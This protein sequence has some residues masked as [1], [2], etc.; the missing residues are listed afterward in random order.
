MLL[1]PLAAQRDRFQDLAEGYRIF[2]AKSVKPVPTEPN[3]QQAL[4]KWSGAIEFKDKLYRGTADCTVLL[5]RIRKSK[6]P[7]TGV[8]AGGAPAEGGGEPRDQDDEADAT[9]RDEVIAARNG[10]TT[11]DEFLKRR[12]LPSDLEAVD[13]EKPL[14]SKDGVPFVARKVIGKVFDFRKREEN[15]VAVIRTYML[16]D[17]AEYFGLVAQG[18]WLDPWKDLVE[19][20]AKSLQ[21]TELGADDVESSDSKFGNQEFRDAVRKK[22]VKG[23]RAFD[24]EHFVFV[25]NTKDSGLIQQIMVDLELMRLNYIERF[26]PVA[27]VDLDQVISAVRFC[28]TYDDYQAYGGPPGT[29]GYWNFVDEELVL[30]DMQTLDEKAYRRNPELK[31]IQV[32]D[33]LYH[34]AMH[35]YFFYANG[36]LAPASWFNEGFGEVFAGAVPDRRKNEIRKIDKN[37]FRLAVI[38]LAQ[39]D[40]SW[41]DL[42]KLLRMT[43]S[44]FY[45]EGVMRNY[46]FGW[47]LCYFLE[48]QRKDAKGNKDWGA[49]PDV[50]LKNLREATRKKREQLKIDEKDKKW[51]LPLQDE[52]QKAAYEATFGTVDLVALRKAWIKAM[53]SWKR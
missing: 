47:A 12:G 52:L 7:A 3:E 23:W 18:P 28:S 2:V 33:I 50:Y 40:D 31:H 16:E 37:R 38:K 10:G 32:L 53:A 51:L 46:A 48:E 34:E 26:P 39:K 19:D 14:K 11:V 21:R 5:V 43:Q 49:L 25:T 1:V 20:M 42:E 9:V 41:P 29:G 36:N 24:T 15:Q 22:L 45:G 17:D 44:Q 4:A 27:G 6:G 13:G 8:A 35:Q 30:V